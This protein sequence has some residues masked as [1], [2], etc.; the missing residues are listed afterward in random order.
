MCALRLIDFIGSE[1]DMIGPIVHV[2]QWV[3]YIRMYV[4]YHYRIWQY[5]SR[6]VV[7]FTSSLVPLY[8]ES[9]DW[10]GAS[11]E[12]VIYSSRFHG[13]LAHIIGTQLQLCANDVDAFGNGEK[14]ALIQCQV[15]SVVGCLI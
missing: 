11:L 8:I 1:A 15:I 2:R 3:Q 12:A 4:V 7:V 14:S 9:F 10:Q 6:T 13:F 5:N